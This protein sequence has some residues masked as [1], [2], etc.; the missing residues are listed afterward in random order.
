MSVSANR[1]YVD[2]PAPSVVLVTLLLLGI[3]AA[4]GMTP[5]TIAEAPGRVPAW[6]V[7]TLALTV[8]VLGL[9]F[10]A[11]YTTYYTLNSQGLEVRY[12]PWRRLYP[13]T[14]FE[15]AMWR[16]G[17]FATRIGWPTITPCVR[18]TNAV[19]LRRRSGGFGLYLTPNDPRA[20]L[21][22]IGEFAPELTAEAIL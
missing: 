7:A 16:R 11:I 1:R 14:D 19:Q 8:A 10:W 21:L 17:M 22:K 20:F 5:T 13:W 12:G 3:F 18:L 2:H 6:I 15:A 4:I 9:F